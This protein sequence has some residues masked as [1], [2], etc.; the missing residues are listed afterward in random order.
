MHTR[1]TTALTTAL[2]LATLTACG[3]SSTT[4]DPAACKTAMAKQ[5]EDAIAAGDQ[6]EQSDRPAACEG[7]DDKTVQRLVGEVTAEQLEGIGDGL[8][9]ALNELGETPTP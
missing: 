9:D 2:L 8:D 4:A 7:L 6:A 3:G 5:F 1:I